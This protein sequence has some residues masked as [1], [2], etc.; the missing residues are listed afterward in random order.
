MMLQAGGKVKSV[1][2]ERATFRWNPHRM[3]RR[4]I[5]EKMMLRI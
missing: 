2:R 5:Y 3:C 1:T 4:P